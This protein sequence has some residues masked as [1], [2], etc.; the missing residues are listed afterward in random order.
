MENYQKQQREAEE[1]EISYRQLRENALQKITQKQ[2]QFSERIS[3]FLL[4]LDSKHK[5]MTDN[6]S[7]CIQTQCQSLNAHIQLKKNAEDKQSKMYAVDDKFFN[8]TH[9]KEYVFANLEDEPVINDYNKCVDTCGKSLHMMRF[10][11]EYQLREFHLNFNEC[12]Y[13]CRL[14]TSNTIGCNYRCFD[15]YNQVFNDVELKL[16]SEYDKYIQNIV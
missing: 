2:Q 13:F 9:D 10:E 8:D 16:N 6:Y 4:N 5:V 14:D 11:L 1:E 3:T 7:K 12:F 15:V